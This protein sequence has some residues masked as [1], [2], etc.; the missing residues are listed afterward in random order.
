ML[1]DALHSKEQ[2]Q[3][4]RA[5]PLRQGEAV[6]FSHRVIHWGSKGRAGPP[7]VAPRLAI[8]FAFADDDFEPPYIE[9]YSAV[10]HETRAMSVW[11]V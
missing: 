3:H 2:Y 1:R 7:V 11:G 8:S 4:I 10:E 9:R 6:V 5:V